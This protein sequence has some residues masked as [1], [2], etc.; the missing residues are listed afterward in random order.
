ML[1]IWRYLSLLCAGR[2]ASSASSRMISRL[3]TSVKQS[4]VPFSC[5]NETKII[6]LGSRFYN[7][8][9]TVCEHGWF[10]A[11]NRGIIR[12]HIIPNQD[13]KVA[14][15]KKKWPSLKT[16]PET[17]AS[18]VQ[19]QWDLAVAPAECWSHKR[20]VFCVIEQSCENQCINMLKK[21]TQNHACSFKCTRKTQSQMNTSGSKL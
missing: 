3:G 9:R 7:W 11:V 19:P 16:I 18:L 12:Y 8:L 1:C 10:N 13:P 2:S 5:S 4:P 14:D 21:N 20:L 17:T 6:C 15:M